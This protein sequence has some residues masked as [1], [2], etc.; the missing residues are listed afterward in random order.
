MCISILPI[1]YTP[2]EKRWAN[3]QIHKKVLLLLNRVG[4]R[5]V[6]THQIW[7]NQR[8]APLNR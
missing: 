7:H 6:C 3:V 1:I 5:G 2:V 4:Q 8:S